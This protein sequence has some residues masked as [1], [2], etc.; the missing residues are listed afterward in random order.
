MFMCRACG[1]PED[2]ADETINRVTAKISDIAPDYQ[3]DPA[4]YFYGVAKKVHREYLRKANR[5]AQPMPIEVT[6]E[7]EQIY[8]CLDRCMETLPEKSRQLVLGYYQNEKRGKIDHRKTLAD[9]LGMICART[10]RS[11]LPRQTRSPG[12]M[13]L[14]LAI[15]DR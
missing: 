4:L 7:D 3:G 6:N 13:G 2:L 5:L 15:V 14:P 10:Q 12:S 11:E 8:E 1:E 9:E